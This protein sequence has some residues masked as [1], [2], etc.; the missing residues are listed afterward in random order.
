MKINHSKPYF[1]DEDT[2]SLINVLH[3]KFLT[4]GISSVEFAGLCAEI[5]GREYGIAT[6][7]G[8][9][10]LTAAFTA[11]KL[12]ENSEV[13]VPAYICSAPLDALALCGLKPFPV[14]IDKNTL[15]IS[16][17][18]VNALNNVSSVL[19]AHLFGLPAPFYLID[20]KNLI[21]DCA[22][23]LNTE[24]NG[25]RVGSMG[26]ISISSFYATKLLATGHGGV[27]AVDDKEL[28]DTM[29]NLMEHDKQDE[30]SPHLHFLMSDLNAALGLSQ[31][32]KLPLLIE[33][34]RTIALRFLKALD[35]EESYVPSNVY[36]RFIV[37]TEESADLMIDKFQKAGIDAKRPV[38]KPLFQYLGLSSDDFPNAQWAHEH[39]VSVPLYPALT[40]TETDCIET[41][42]EKY[43]NELCCRTSA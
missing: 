22:Q 6:Q 5:L 33:K 18:S 34:R 31:L 41:F 9:D 10:A 23:T 8:T 3:R 30:W 27:V 40:E 19:A 37:I 38:Y 32:K 24:L 15:A 35:A 2:E 7:S 4:Y 29:M 1:D 13:A 11:L 39:I 26:R 12:P 25:V 16:V 43:R 20:N 21:E 42:L 17:E 36:S 14:D 28:F